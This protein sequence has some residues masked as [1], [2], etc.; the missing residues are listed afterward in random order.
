MDDRRSANML[1]RSKAL[2]ASS[3]AST[4]RVCTTPTMASTVPSPT[5]R[6]E[7]GES[8]M[9]LRPVASSQERFSQSTSVRGVITARTARSPRRNDAGDHARSSDSI[10]PWCS[11]SATRSLISSSVTF[12]SDCPLWPSRRST[13]RPEMSSSQTAGRPP[14][15]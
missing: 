6:R 7:C 13:S 14:W 15:R 4:S 5:G 10:V 1:A 2:P 3:A 8:M 12:S 11:A 9:A